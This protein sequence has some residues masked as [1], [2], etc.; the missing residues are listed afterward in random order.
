[1]WWII[2][3]VLEYEY[4]KEA[5]S[6]YARIW[7]THL[8]ICCHG[9]VKCLRF[10]FINLLCWDDVIYD[11]PKR[12][13]YSKKYGV[14]LIRYTHAANTVVYSSNKIDGML[15]H[16]FCLWFKCWFSWLDV[17]TTNEGMGPVVTLWKI[18]AL[19]FHCNVCNC[20]AARPDPKHLLLDRGKPALTLDWGSCLYSLRV[21]DSA[22]YRS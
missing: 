18:E 9:H 17:K 2:C 4:K 19:S 5:A 7:K 1:M 10:L 14:D 21:R 16:V 8:V 11:R 20:W 22:P 13:L 3:F 12:T 6:L 15:T